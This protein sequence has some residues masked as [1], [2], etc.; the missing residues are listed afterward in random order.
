MVPGTEYS[1]VMFQGLDASIYGSRDC[2]QLFMVPG[3]GYIVHDFPGAPVYGSK[4]MMKNDWK[5]L[6]MV[7]T[8]VYNCLWFS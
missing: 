4:D 1:G 6:F 3:T 7:L 5:Q 2:I 8:A